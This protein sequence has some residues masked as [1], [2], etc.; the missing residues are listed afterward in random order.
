LFAD[1]GIPH[2]WATKVIE[3]NTEKLSYDWQK[4]TLNPRNNHPNYLYNRLVAEQLLHR[5]L[6]ETAAGNNS[7]T[8]RQTSD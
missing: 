7:S 8:A 2:M 1:R 4:F 5:I 3:Q 6:A